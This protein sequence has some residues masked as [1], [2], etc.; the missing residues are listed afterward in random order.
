MAF[1]F[2]VFPEIIEDG[3]LFIAEPPLYR[4]ADKNDPFVINMADYITRYAKAAGKDYTIGYQIGDA[5]PDYM[6]KNTLIEFLTATCNYVDEMNIIIDH[7]KTHGLLLEIILGE[8]ASM[9]V[10]MNDFVNN[11]DM[12]IGKMMKSVDIQNLLNKIRE[13]FPEM[14]YDDNRKLFKGIIEGKYQSVEITAQ[15]IRKCRECIKLI[16]DWGARADEVLVL[17]DRKTKTEH[18]LS[19]LGVLRILKKYQPSILHRFK[20]LGE[21]DYED[22]KTTIMDPNTRTLIKVNITDIENDM[23]IF[24][25]LRGGS[26][27]DAL[28]RKQMMA[29]YRI[30]KNLIDT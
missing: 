25:V 26:P 1:F 27:L 17:R 24:Q 7:Y 4:V 14:N 30:D 18:K 6:D 20:G 2:K 13:K 5:Y 21:N 11:P 29:D 9:D 16:H 8:F 15:F 28:N 3:R 12:Y 22:I 23:K 19:L 10:P